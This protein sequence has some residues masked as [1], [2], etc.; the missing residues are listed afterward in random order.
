MERIIEFVME[1]LRATKK[2][3][4][5]NIQLLEILGTLC[6]CKGVAVEQNQSKNEHIHSL[7]PRLQGGGHSWV[8]N[9][10][11]PGIHNFKKT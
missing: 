8:N 1:K 2:A 11:S 7:L 6:V 9:N 4:D 5:K 10:N 3:S